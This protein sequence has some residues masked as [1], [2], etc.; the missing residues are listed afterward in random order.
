[1]LLL[2]LLLLRLLLLQCRDLP[3]LALLGRG[4]PAII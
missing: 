2:L 3:L 4:L 1:V